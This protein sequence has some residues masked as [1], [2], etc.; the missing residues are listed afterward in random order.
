MPIKKIFR[1]VVMLFAMTALV[2]TGLVQGQ[3]VSVNGGSIQG[4]I[5]DPTG[6]VVAGAQ[7]TIVGT[8]TGSTKTVVTDSAGLYSV[9]PLNPGNYTVNVTAGGFQ[10]LS[11]KTVIRT[12]TA[13]SGNFR[14]ILGQSTETVEVNAGALQVQT[15]QI[16]VSD[17]ITRD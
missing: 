2:Q 3:A 1:L 5:T 8:D 12:G 15:E 17:V 6:A 16:S 10:K 11:V 13:T 4:T 14:L 9:G 7:I